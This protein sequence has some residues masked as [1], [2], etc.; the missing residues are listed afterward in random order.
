MAFAIV[1]KKSG[2]S[3]RFLTYTQP[4]E[5]PAG[6]TWLISMVQRQ[7]AS[8]NIV[9]IQTAQPPYINENTHE[10]RKIKNSHLGH[11]LACAH[12]LLADIFHGVLRNGHP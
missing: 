1:R 3:L 5:R 2:K 9:Q 10:N 6:M 7:T 8:Y 12:D 11:G 4:G